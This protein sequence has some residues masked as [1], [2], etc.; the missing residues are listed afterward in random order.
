[1]QS[2]KEETQRW[3]QSELGWWIRSRSIVCLKGKESLSI[4]HTQS[5]SKAVWLVLHYECPRSIIGI[6]EEGSETWKTLH[7]VKIEGRYLKCY[8]PHT[9]D[10]F[11]FH[12]TSQSW[13]LHAE[14]NNKFQNTHLHIERLPKQ[15]SCFG[16]LPHHLPNEGNISKIKFILSFWKQLTEVASQ[17]AQTVKNLHVM[18]ETWVRSLG[19]K[20]PLEQG[21]AYD[22]SRMDRGVWQVIVY[23]GAQNST[24]LW[25][26]SMDAR[27]MFTH[28]GK[29]VCFF[30]CVRVCYSPSRIRL[31]VI[32]LTVAQQ[33]PLSMQPSRQES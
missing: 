6:R 3:T 24:W 19:W 20:D 29:L 23:E 10:I 18:H 9:L 7:K 1:M 17:V 33:T 15:A 22:S 25:Q 14:N 30:V 32:P 26:V 2:P 5:Q 11:L 8:E 28:Y 13:T 31:S 4:V 21:L 12:C 27:Q 16:W